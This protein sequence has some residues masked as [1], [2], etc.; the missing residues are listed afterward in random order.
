LEDLGVDER[1]I[2]ESLSKEK[3]EDVDSTDLT[4]DRDEWLLLET[5]Y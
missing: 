4:W 1:T 3:A 5:L 2:L